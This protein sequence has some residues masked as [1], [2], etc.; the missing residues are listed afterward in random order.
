[1]RMLKAFLISWA[2][3]ILTVFMWPVLTAQA[4]TQLKYGQAVRGTLNPSHTT[5]EYA[6]NGKTGDKLTIVMNALEGDLDPLLN[7]YDPQGRLIGEN[8]NG[9][10]KD[11]AKMSGIV[12]SADG[13]YKVVAKNIAQGTSGN[14]SL[15]ISEEL[16][17]GAPIN[18]E[19]QE[20]KEAYQLS[21]PW[22][23]TS[24]TY[25]IANSLQNFNPQDVRATIQQAW[26]AWSSVVPLSFRE[27]QSG[28]ADIVIQFGSID[29]P[30][31]VL[32]QACPPSS[33]C[34]GQVEFDSD[35]TWILGTPRTTRDISFL[36]VATH[37]FG[38]II[39]LLHSS[40][41]TALMYPSYSPYNLK[42]NTDDIQGVQRLY[43]AGRGGVPTAQPGTGGGTGGQGGTGKPQVQETINNNQF[44]NFWDFDVD[45]G[46]TITVTMKR[47]SGNLDSF[48][49]LL[50]ANN[51]ILAYDDDSA[52]NK[53]AVL[54]NIRV[55]QRGTYT[56][57][58]TRYKQAQGYSQ[59]NYTL[60]IN[61]GQTS[62]PPAAPTTAANQ[63]RG[64]A[65][66]RV[67]AGQPASLQQNP[68]LD[69][70][71]NTAFNE[72]VM[73]EKQTRNATVQSS[74]TYNWSTTWCANN[75]QT[76]SQNLAN[77]AVTFAVNGTPVDSKTVTQTQPH[78]AQNGLS[79]VDYFVVL[80]D[81]Q[82]GQVT[83]TKTMTLRSP[84]YDGMTVY[85]P[86]DYVYEYV[87]NVSDSR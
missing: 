59:G 57:A 67:S 64:T 53:D 31:N 54:R 33:P 81:W 71:L 58:A 7:L 2:L 79:C 78:N 76:L 35:E 49:V 9:G 1:M 43:G 11:G 63:P 8:T 40:D 16:A 12:L 85:A 26:Q 27:V 83:L 10:G 44:A 69:S 17:K 21:R 86:G 65:S 39:G 15:V 13:V 19:G 82:P 74:Q 68:S 52:G 38:H 72:S 84:V 60:T 14:Y 42:P 36:A 3:L 5:D 46:E 80:S 73:P 62:A 47:A 56:V 66:V 87:V 32:G 29:G 37:E 55:P 48:L 34:S 18:Y 70:V 41:A 4:A 20:T 6:F 25:R 22:D 30:L 50:D 28:N 24:L 51:H 23:H 77:I 75:A 61:Y 45:A